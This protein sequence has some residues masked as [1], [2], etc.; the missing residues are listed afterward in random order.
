MMSFAR[1]SDVSGALA[2]DFGLRIDFFMMD[3]C[4]KGG[5]RFGGTAARMA[6]TCRMSARESIAGS[7]RLGGVGAQT[8]QMTT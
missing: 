7:L 5:K 6:A 8:A 2:D 3:Q 1:S 4:R